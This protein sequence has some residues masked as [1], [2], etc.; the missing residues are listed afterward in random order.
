MRSRSLA[1]SRRRPATRYT[2]LVPNAARPRRRPRG[3]PHRSGDFRRRLRDLQP[4]QHQPDRRCVAGG[5]RRGD[6]ARAG[7][8]GSAFA[9][10]CPRRSDV[11][12]RARPA[13]HAWSS[14]TNGCWRLGVFEVAVSDTIGVATPGQVVELV[15]ALEARVPIA[16][17]ALH[18][19]D[20]RGTA[21]ANVLRRARAPASPRS[22]RR[23][24]GWAAAPLR[25]AR[26]ATSPPKTCS[27][28]CTASASRPASTSTPSSRPRGSSRPALGHALPSRYLQA[29]RSS[30]A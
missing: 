20:T 27:T 8:W 12:S 9:D 30:Y 13:R 26:L 4:T 28:C 6:P 22:T 24:A 21:L 16:A 18:L 7:R 1:A 2:A 25:R 10:T 19:H 3:R 15:E 5:L 14:S 29:D 23:L 11:R 17:L